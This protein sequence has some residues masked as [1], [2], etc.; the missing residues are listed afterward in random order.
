[1]QNVLFSS[2]AGVAQALAAVEK[3]VLNQV[4]TWMMLGLALTAAVAWYCADTADIRSFLLQNRWVMWVLILGELGLVFAISGLIN[5][6]SA[7]A[8]TSLFFIYS[9]LN[10]ITLS[11][12]FMVFN[13]GSIAGVFLITA[14]TFGIMSLYGLTTQRD[15]SS[16]GNL[17]LMALIGLVIAGVV[18]LFITSS[19]MNMII[20]AIGVLVFTGLTAYDA[21]RIKEMAASALDGESEGKLAVIGALSLYLNFINLFLSLLNLFGGRNEE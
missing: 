11:T 6:I 9:A 18:N 1:M 12:I 7:V 19:V 20:S 21:Q 10:G 16:L 14:G 4:Y 2:R 13:L 5:R 3:R 17:L 15:L 8:A